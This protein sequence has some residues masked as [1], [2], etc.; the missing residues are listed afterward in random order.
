MQ[1]FLTRG[2]VFCFQ[3]ELSNYVL[4]MWSKTHRNHFQQEVKLRYLF[5]LVSSESG[6]DVIWFEALISAPPPPVIITSLI[7]SFFYK[8]FHTNVSGDP[9]KCFWEIEKAT[10]IS[11]SLC[12]KNHPTMHDRAVTENPLFISLSAVH[13]LPCVEY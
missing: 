10:I 11:W 6:F 7:H 5:V 12:L 13:I 1:M 2:T 8:T 3:Y 9:R 4:R